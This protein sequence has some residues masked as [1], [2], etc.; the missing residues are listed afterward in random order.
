MLRTM[1]VPKETIEK[2]IIFHRGK[3]LILAAMLKRIKSTNLNVYKTYSALFRRLSTCL[4]CWV[5]DETF[6][7]IMITHTAKA[8]AP[9]GMWLF[10]LLM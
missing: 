7:R 8:A 10:E 9:V 2:V 1:H 3:L 6:V 4:L 5:Y